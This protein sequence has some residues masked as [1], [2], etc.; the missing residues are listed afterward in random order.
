MLVVL[1]LVDFELYKVFVWIKNTH[2]S[3]DD[4][5]IESNVNICSV[6][7]IFPFFYRSIIVYHVIPSIYHFLLKL[8]QK[9][10]TLK[11]RGTRVI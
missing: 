5:S 6:T 4:K 3:I 11:Q 8:V 7:F 10:S 2:H 1:K 9:R